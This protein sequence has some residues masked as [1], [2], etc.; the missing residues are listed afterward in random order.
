MHTRKYEYIHKYI[1]THL[2]GSLLWLGCFDLRTYAN[3]STFY[4]KM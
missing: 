1:Y 3:Y 2:V 4:I